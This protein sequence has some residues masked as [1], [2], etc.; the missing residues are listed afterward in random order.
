VITVTGDGALNSPQTVANTYVVG[1]APPKKTQTP[2]ALAFAAAAG[3]ADPVAQTVTISNIGGEPLEW[4]V[5]ATPTWI[6]VTPASGTVAP[7]GST[8][9][10]VSASIPAQSGLTSGYVVFATNAPGHPSLP[11]SIDVWTPDTAP[12]VVTVPGN[13]TREATDGSGAIVTFTASAS[14]LVDGPVAVACAPASGSTF[15]LGPTMVTCSAGDAAGN[16]GSGSFSVTVRDTTAPVLS[17]PANIVRQAASASGIAVTFSV[18]AADTVSGSRPVSCVPTS[19]A[20]FPVGTTTVT[21]TA[22]DAAGNPVSGTFT[23]Q[24]LAPIVSFVT[25]SSGLIFQTGRLAYCNGIPVGPN[26]KDQGFQVTNTGNTPLPYSISTSTA[27]LRIVP[28]SGTVPV[29][30]TVML[31]VSVDLTGLSQ[32]TW[33]G[34]FVVSAAGG[35]SQTV[36]VALNIG[37]APATLCLTPSFINFGKIRAGKT[38]SKTFDVL[39]V[40]DDPLG[41]WSLVKTATQGTVTTSAS[42]GS[43]PKRITVTVKAGTTKTAQSGTV[44]VTAPGAVLGTQTTNLSWIVY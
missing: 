30:G 36:P 5:V 8:T 4:N 9:L 41:S 25:S 11:V 15:P 6:S 37:K 27:W 35:P 7:G 3:G 42:S 12:P 34:A 20:V 31:V 16:Q 14:D 32:G 33:N 19:G 29:G 38:L 10:T 18:S 13:L 21:C 44:T 2:S 22:A 40:G 43:G 23:V 28:S 17:L 1:D 24:V 39:N 26:W